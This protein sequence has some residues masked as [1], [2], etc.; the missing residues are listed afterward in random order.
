M[1]IPRT[2]V[3]DPCGHREP[4]SGPLA[5][6]QVLSHFMHPQLV[7]FLSHTYWFTNMCFAYFRVSLSTKLKVSVRTFEWRLTPLVLEICKSA[8]AGRSL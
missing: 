6:Q 4:N 5:E 8:E 1:W 3:R 2:K 7:I